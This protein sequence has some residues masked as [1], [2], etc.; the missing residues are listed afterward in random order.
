MRIFALLKGVSS[1]DVEQEIEDRL[2][3]TD[4]LNV[5]DQQVGSFSGGMKRRLSVCISTIGNP[6]VILLD[7]PT[8][9]M[10]PVNRRQVWSMIEKLKAGRCVILT[11]HNME[12]VDTLGDCIAIMAYGKIRAIGTGLH[13]KNKF[14]SGYHLNI[15]A[16]IPSLVPQVMD[17][18]KQNVSSAVLL[19][20]DAGNMSISIPHADHSNIP[21]LLRVL[22]E[23]GKKVQEGQSMDANENTSGII[24]EWELSLSTLE[25]VF[26]VVAKQSHFEYIR[27]DEQTESS[28]S[29][30][31]STKSLTAQ[32]S[33]E[34]VPR[35]TSEARNS[36]QLE[37]KKSSNRSYVDVDYL[38]EP[39]QF[40][41]LFLKNM[42]LQ[43]RQKGQNTCQI[44]TPMFVIGLLLLLQ[45]I[46][47][48][49]LKDQVREKI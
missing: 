47:K 10:D 16:T 12:E 3:Y 9:G 43:S 44:I 4:L 46:I 15:V 26:L 38:D 18:V 25:E 28:S 22:E 7:E 17:L 11:S 35:T 39:K 36:D 20:N 5:A 1:D 30:K 33:F 27:R 48:T 31:I 6:D 23:E 34:F 24:R 14:G 13:L 21:S 41:A 49:Q 37:G 29:D 2:S 45:L 19:E 32:R 8:T 42:V 40:R